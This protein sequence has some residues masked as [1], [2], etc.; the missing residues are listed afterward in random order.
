MMRQG[1]IWYANLNPTRGSEQA[2]TRPVVIVSGN[3][4]NE[5]L[6]IVIVLPIT[7][8][9]KSYPTCVALSPNKTNGLS[10][11]SEIIPFQVR[12]VTKKRLTKK[13]G[14][15]SRKELQSALKGLAHVLT[16]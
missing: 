7:G 5:T 1:E 2:G 8:K 11:D 13:I 14:T 16:Q 6:P 15:L 3:T 12:T 9:I 10:V 4:L